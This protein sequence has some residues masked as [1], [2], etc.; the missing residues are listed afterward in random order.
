MRRGRRKLR[1]PRGVLGWLGLAVGVTAVSFGVGWL[2]SVLILF[3]APA[4]AGA[5]VAA[6]DVRRMPLAEAEAQLRATG[7]AIAAPLR[8]ASRE[9]EGDVIA[10]DP[11]PGQHVRPGAAVRLVVSEGPAHPRVPPLRGMDAEQATALLQQLD[12]EVGR[13]DEMSVLAPGLVV[14]TRPPEG[15]EL[16]PPQSVLLVVSSGPPPPLEPSAVDSMGVIPPA[17]G[18]GRD[19]P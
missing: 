3:P 5:G 11:L 9:T 19:R 1:R 6:P 18:V 10:Q 12:I 15:S 14:H 13:R 7:L 2:V 8:L 4:D 16:A 17:A